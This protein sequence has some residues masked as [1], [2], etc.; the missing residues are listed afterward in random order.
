M[1]DI[2]YKEL[3]HKVNGLCFKTHRELGRFCKER[4]Y[5]D[6]LEEL[7]REAGISYEREYEIKDF[8]SNSPKGNKVDFLIEGKMILDT[9]A[10][11]YLLKEDYVQMQRYL[12]SAGL[13]LGLIVNFRNRHLKPARVL[14]SR[15]SHLGSPDS[16]RAG[17]FTLVEMLFYI[18][19][20]SLVL[21]AV[22]ET[23]IVMTRSYGALRAAQRIEEEAGFA[24][25]RMVREIRDASRITDAGSVF[26]SHPGTVLLTTTTASGAA[27]TVEFYLDS[28]TLMLKEDGAVTGALT[29]ARTGVTNVIFRKITT[30]RSKAVK[31]ELTLTSGTGSAARSESFYATAVLR[32]SY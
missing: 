27:R 21:L 20:L 32:D 25:E 26:G 6:R 15:H 11:P 2:V 17:G 4:Q 31:I 28:G 5:A 9:K 14:N 16:H 7:L 18:A 19:L 22:T 1:S 13:R 12:D 8:N 3:S 23:L 24:L 29:S 10:K 30:A